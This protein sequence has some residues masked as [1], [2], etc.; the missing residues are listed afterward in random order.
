[1]CDGMNAEIDT[2]CEFRKL[3]YEA[4]KRIRPPPPDSAC[5]IYMHEYYT[6]CCKKHHRSSRRHRFF[7]FKID[8]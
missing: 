7:L 4:A 8:L 3:T 5:V 1:M 2:V 6:S